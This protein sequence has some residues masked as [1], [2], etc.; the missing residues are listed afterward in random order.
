VRKSPEMYVILKGSVSCHVARRT[1]DAKAAGF[2][3]DAKELAEVQDAI[4][5]KQA[6]AYTRPLFSST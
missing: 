6:G 4:S 3:P 5:T 2:M 1:L